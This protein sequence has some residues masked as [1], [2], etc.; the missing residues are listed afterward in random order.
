MHPAQLTPRL[1][2]RRMPIGS[3]GA[4]HPLEGCTTESTLA[5]ERKGLVPAGENWWVEEALSRISIS[6]RGVEW[7]ILAGSNN[8]NLCIEAWI[9][10]IFHGRKE[11]AV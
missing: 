10:A 11:E 1:A 7:F 3:V 6:I 4:G 5:G 9:K 2:R 8:L